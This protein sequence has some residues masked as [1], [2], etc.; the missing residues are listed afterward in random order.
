MDN[1]ES[2]VGAEKKR[3]ILYDENTIHS[4]VGLQLLNMIETSRDDS[5]QDNLFKIT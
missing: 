1:L 4:V 5:E 3:N 2:M